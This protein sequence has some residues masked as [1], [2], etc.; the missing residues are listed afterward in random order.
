MSGIYYNGTIEQPGLP[1]VQTLTG[2]SGGAVGADG[3]DNI[4][5]LGASGIIVTGNPGTNTL[6]VS[7]TGATFLAYQAVSTTPFTITVAM[8]YISVDSTSL[9]ITL[10]LPNSSSTGQVYYIKDRVGNCATHNI[11]VTTVG[12]AVNIDGATSYVMNTNYESIG[13]IF[14]GTSYEIF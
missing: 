4:N 2:N 8:D 12:G 11:T 9:A 3:L 10:K 6:T 14:N 13:L 7:G 5:I 1:V